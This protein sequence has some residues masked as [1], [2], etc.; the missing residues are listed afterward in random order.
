MVG[1]IERAAGE[2]TPTDQP[3]LPIQLLVLLAALAAGVVAQGGYYPPGRLVVTG[4]VV[5][6]TLI[7]WWRHRTWPGG[8]WMVAAV[9]GALALWALL[10]TIPAGGVAPPI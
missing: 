6:A 3:D 7:A 1:L 8:L 4:L 2:G 5:A 10:R 9:A